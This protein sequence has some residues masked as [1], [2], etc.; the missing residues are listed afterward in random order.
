MACSLASLPMAAGPPAA[1][2]A[3]STASNLPI[4]RHLLYTM[5]LLQED[6]AVPKDYD[7]G[8]VLLDELGGQCVNCM[9]R[10]A[11][12]RGPLHDLA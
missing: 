9:A 4:I 12:G 1:T 11:G 7:V 10:Q 6:M 3:D 8:V 2:A 5:V